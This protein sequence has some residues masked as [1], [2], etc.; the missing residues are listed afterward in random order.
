MIRLMIFILIAIFAYI[1][2]KMF[3]FL[4]KISKAADN[5]QRESKFRRNPNSKIN[6]KKEDIIE[7]DFEEIEPDKSESK[8]SKQ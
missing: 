4:K 6:I 8:T 7:A 5:T 1:A 2:F 3:R